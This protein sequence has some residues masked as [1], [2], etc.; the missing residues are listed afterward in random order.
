MLWNPM[1]PAPAACSPIA[2]W[3]PCRWAALAVA[4]LLCLVGTGEAAQ[5]S[6]YF[7]TIGSA[8]GLAQNT[9]HALLRDPRG[10]VWVA[11]QGGLHRYDG[12]GF[13]LFQ[14]DPT[15]TGSLPENFL[16]ALAPGG[17]GW[18]WVGTNSNFVAALDLASGRAVRHP[19][20][21]PVGADPERNHVVALQPSA[22]GGLWITTG[23][24]IEHYDP[25]SQQRELVLALDRV[26]RNDRRGVPNLAEMAF[27]RDGRL[28]VA[29]ASGLIMID[30]TT[31][32]ATAVGPRAAAFGLHR[33]ERQRLWAGTEHGLFEIDGEQLRSVGAGGGAPIGP[34]WRLTS[35]RRGRLWLALLGGGLLRY[36][37][38][39][40]D[41]LPLQYEPDLPHSL[42]EATVLTLMVDPSGLLWLGGESRGLATTHADGAHFPLL[43]DTRRDVETESGNNVR[44]I[45]QDADGHLWLGTDANGL[46][47]VDL[48]NGRFENR[49]LA[50]N[51]ALN[52]PPA[53]RG[54][55]I[56]GIENGEQGRLWIGT[57][58]GVFDYDPDSDRARL[59]SEPAVRAGL[60]PD[61]HFR[62][63]RRAFDGSLWIGTYSAGL[64][65]YW[66]KTG[67]WRMYSHD[68]A[69]P[70]SIGHGLINCVLEE[71]GGRLW[72]GTLNGLSLIDVASGR[73]RRYTHDPNDPQSLSGNLVR[74]IHQGSDGRLWVAT[75]S[76]LNELVEETADGRLRFR[77]HGSDQGLPSNTIYGIREDRR[78]NL[79]LSTNLGLARLNP[80]SGAVRAFGLRDGLQDLEFNGGANFELA[81]GR[82]AFGGI[83]GIN[84]F[85]PSTIED[86]RFEPPV[87]LTRVRIG[88]NAARTV[89]APPPMIEWPQDQH[90]LRLNFAALDYT[91]PRQN[92]FR[93]RIEGFDHEWIDGGTSPEATYTNL[94]PGNYRLRVQAT[95][96]DGI[97]S[98]HEIDLPMTVI[99]PWWNSPAA[100]ALYLLTG[101]AALL[102]FVLAQQ[103][104]RASEQRFVQQIQEREERLKLALWGSGDE[105]WDW[106]VQHNT[107]YRV[108][109]DQLLG[110]STD[111]QLS[112][113]DWRNR[114]LHPD[115]LPRVQAV[116][117]AHITGQT[118]A[119]DSEHRLRN[120]AGE[121]IWVR[122]RGKVVERDTAGNPLRIAGT[123]RDITLTRR[124]ERER[125]IAIEVLR[126]MGEAV[127][128]IDLD[129]RFVSVNPAFSRI[130]GYSEDEVRG[131]PSDLLDS[132]QHSADFYQR[133]RRTAQQL[134][135]WKGEIWQKRK[136]GEEFLGWIEL[137]EVRDERG[138]R[139]HY[140]AV[141]TDITDKK[142][143]EQE[144]LYLANY[145]TLTGLPNRALLAER[146]A[147]AVV[148][149]R[150]QDCRVAVLFLDLDRFKDINDSLGHAA[151]DRL[152]KAAAARLLATV[153]ETDTVA[154]LGGD[155]FTV[156]L[157]DLTDPLGAEDMAARIVA[158][159]AEPLDLD[160]RSETVISPSIG[161]ALYPDHG[162]VPTDLLKFAD[163]AMYEAKGRGRNTWQLYSEAMDAET[164]RRAN[165]LA[166]LRRALD[167][168]ELR[169][170]FQPKVS[171]AQR[172][173][174][175]VEALLR[176]NSAELGEISPAYFIP[177]AEETGLILPIGEWVLREAAQTLQQWRTA[178]LTEVAMAI[179]VSML[180]FLRSRLAEQVAAIVAETGVPAARLELEVTES[181]VMAN[182]EQAIRVMRELKQIGL[183]LA[184]DDFGTGYSSLVYLKRLPIDTL[185][186]DK[187]FIGDLTTD[188]DDEAI[189]ATVITM[190]HSLG[191]N[192]VAEGVENAE[193]L[194]YLREHRCDEI[195]G[196]HLARPMDGA[197]CLQ[198]IREFDYAERLQP[199]SVADPS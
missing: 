16:T 38:A 102:L 193:Q 46:K 195:Q 42:P 130:T 32:V 191:L 182:A 155:E 144:L 48:V 166:A 82:L 94:D 75:H 85:D 197:H 131:R 129:F 70:Q 152:L 165:V 79:W 80:H 26:V 2:A 5:R 117:Q 35:D 146:L 153:R 69:D 19:G 118:D 63:I 21:L 68:P 157:E 72:V 192:V 96:H 93:Y 101:V 181:M 76:G 127:G 55:R 90:V 177:L 11:T 123:A 168:G 77:R 51:R 66:P 47:H 74:A 53:A 3:S 172:R 125:R 199:A 151:G 106:D 145:D 194:Q 115:D 27:D 83:R 161:I 196:F 188:P 36:D 8:D 23:A 20:T 58:H 110:L 88:A 163:T 139:T 162:Q 185:K 113:D 126:S 54:I 132:A 108:G 18:I 12:Y 158:A 138:E 133:L 114:S 34:V 150:R 17:D 15:D 61:S 25:Q 33:D 140:V 109:A 44:A 142:R 10:F 164:R 29:A 107:I 91:A 175:G 86:S 167:R 186:I 149:A 99:A 37:P 137:S 22:D 174:T 100:R 159:F 13:T 89:L 121:W 116:M 169:L 56:L 30:P 60:V 171:L 7:E 1:R 67:E 120:A 40:G 180:Q 124:A 173:V 95:N 9:V 92:R 143:A 176:W 160:G 103:R 24:S 156:V 28:W 104:R 87:V 112:T 78:G 190:A 43:L 59:V 135:H 128:V 39:S 179:N 170:V 97:W 184:I 105:F 41:T 119:F 52:H 73:T 6:H 50:L 14:H 111:Q 148:R 62:F 31:R 136:D 84:V 147:R 81:D 71:Q 134:G 64:A 122:S 45:V 98:S 189:T 141:V 65:R 183:T 198:F 49:I 187:E 57:D 154:R 4:A 178:G